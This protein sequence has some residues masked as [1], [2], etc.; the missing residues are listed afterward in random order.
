MMGIV[1]AVQTCIIC[2]LSCVIY[3]LRRRDRYKCTICTR[4]RKNP[5]ISEMVRKNLYEGYC[6]MAGCHRRSIR[7]GG[8]SKCSKHIG[9]N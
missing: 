8:H 6:D 7:V 4:V 2:M 1:I 5:A 9:N 3:T